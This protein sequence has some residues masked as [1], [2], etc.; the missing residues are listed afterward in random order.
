MEPEFVISVM[1]GNTPEGTGGFQKGTIGTFSTGWPLLLASAWIAVTVVVGAQSGG[2][3]TSQDV[4]TI[5]L[6]VATMAGV[7]GAVAWSRLPAASG[8]VLPFVSLCATISAIL[9]VT[10]V[11]SLGKSE[12]LAAFLLQAPWH[13]ALI[14]VT[15]H[16]SLA[17]G[18]PGRQRIWLGIVVGWYLLHLAMFVSA[19][20]GLATGELPLYQTVEST[21]RQR[22]LDPAGI[23]VALASLTLALVSPSIGRR[24]RRAVI[25]AGLAIGAGLIPTALAWLIPFLTNSLDGAMTPVRLALAFTPFLGLAATLALPYA[26]PLRR[27]LRAHQVT[28]ALLD[29]SDLSVGIRRFA[30]LLQQEFEAE[31]VAVRLQHPALSESVGTL[32]PRT[33]TA[34]AVDTELDE[35]RRILVMPVG[36]VGDPLGEIRVVATN[37]GMYGKRERE[38]LA[39]ILLP[40]APVLRARVRE[41]K[42]RE[43]LEGLTGD[44][45]TASTSL[46]RLAAELPTTKAEDAAGIPPEVDASLVL[47][48][49]SDILDGVTRRTEGLE[50][51][52]GSGRGHI[53][54]ANDEIAQG[55]D[56]LRGLTSELL[57]LNSARDEIANSNLAVS[58]VAFRTNLL[59][60]NAALEA[61]RAGELG[62]T[63]GVLA[64]EIRR[65][66]DLTSAASAEIEQRT[67]AL[68]SEVAQLVTSLERVQSMLVTAIREA[69]AGE[70]AT[71][72]VTES[73]G[74]VLGWTR[75]LKP[76][77]E[78]TYAVAARRSARDHKLTLQAQAMLDER[79]TREV[80]MDQVRAAIHHVRTTLEQSVGTSGTPS[81]AAPPSPP[82]TASAPSLSPSSRG[83]TSPSA[84]PRR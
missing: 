84:P 18:W 1:G 20:G 27:D 17:V 73:A 32:P 39:A 79:A 78:E 77:V 62:Q 7:A 24:Q 29:E 36:R 31:G 42:S 22:I 4:A 2:R 6:L 64:E 13:Y 28:H 54:L 19:A 48:Q 60:N 67:V 34:L 45:R 82:P 83:A 12:S 40:L 43:H 41:V 8:V 46:S 70:D 49:L 59:A 53:R 63:F 52:A 68:S 75:S 66:A 35:E 26:D 14:P 55:L 61:N 15:L 57:H 10:T 9:A 56:A 16:F 5:L 37:V 25:W 69:E 50:E 74:A 71:A 72:R 3:T 65:L 80:R 23:V 81:S 38:W 58:G 44:I 30:A 21:F 51:M 33:E 11:E 47:H 76:V